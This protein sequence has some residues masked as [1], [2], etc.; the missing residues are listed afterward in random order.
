MAAKLARMKIRAEGNPTPSNTPSFQ[1]PL[2][3]KP[4]AQKS[5]PNNVGNN[6]GPTNQNQLPITPHKKESI[7]DDNPNRPV[8]PAPKP[9]ISA[10]QQRILD[11]QA[12]AKEQNATSPPVSRIYVN[13]SQILNINL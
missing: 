4:S 5:A 10:V 7:V 3:P 2:P 6:N 9:G 12:R 8:Q 1:K 13:T 11:A